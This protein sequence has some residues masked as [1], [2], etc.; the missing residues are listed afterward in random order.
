MSTA[1][2]HVGVTQDAAKAKEMSKAK[3]RGRHEET[4]RPLNHRG[5]VLPFTNYLEESQLIT[6]DDPVLVLLAGVR[7]VVP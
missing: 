1:P 5:I 3:T 2:N 4:P 7:D 6:Q